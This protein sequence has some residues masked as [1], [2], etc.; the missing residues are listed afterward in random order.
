M[1]VVLKALPK[2]FLDRFEESLSAVIL[3][4]MA[5]IAFANVLSRYFFHYSFAFTEE[6]EIAGFVWITVLGAS[7]GFRKG[8]QLAVDILVKHLPVKFRLVLSILSG[9]IS[10]TLFLVLVYFSIVQIGYEIK[11]NTRSPSMNWP[12]YIY[13]LSIPIGSSLIILRVIQYTLEFFRK[14]IKGAHK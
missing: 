14:E 6:L 9:I 7:I 1:E 3:G 4:L 5:T 10:V 12:Q 2:L 13:T 8:N 11:Y